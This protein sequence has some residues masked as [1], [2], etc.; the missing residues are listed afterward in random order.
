NL[1]SEVEAWGMSITYMMIAVVVAG[2]GVIFIYWWMNR[3][4]LTDPFY[5]DMAESEEKKKK[6]NKPKLS[7]RES[8]GYLLSSKYLGFIAVLVISYGITSNIIDVTWKSQLKDYLPYSND[9][10]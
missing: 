9:Y 10:F 2:I 7:L 3:Y 4:V 5:Y 6:E 1:P 8:L